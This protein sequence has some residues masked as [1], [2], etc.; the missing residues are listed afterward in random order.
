MSELYGKVSRHS[1]E[2]RD[3]KFFDAAAPAAIQYRLNDA[4]QALINLTRH[5][6]WLEALKDRRAEQVE[7]GEWP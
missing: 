5:V 1:K 2:L 3:S 6:S 4:K 7:R